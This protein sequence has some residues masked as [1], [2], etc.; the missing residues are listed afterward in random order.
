MCLKQV[1]MKSGIAKFQGELLSDICHLTEF[2]DHDVTDA[3]F[4]D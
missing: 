4:Q 2:Q 1:T 3:V